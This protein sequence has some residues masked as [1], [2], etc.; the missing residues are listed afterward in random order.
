MSTHTLPTANAAGL[1]AERFAK[2]IDGKDTALFVLK[3]NHGMELCVCNY[4][5][6][7]VAIMVPDKA[8]NVKNVVLGHDSIDALINNP[9]PYLGTVV[10]RYAN[11]IALG[12]FTLDGVSYDLA[13]NNGPNSL[14]GGAKGFNFKVWDAEQLDAQTLVL[15]YTSAD[16][17]ENYPGKL[18]VKMTYTL[19]DDNEF[20]IDYEAS[21]DKP[22]LCNLTNHAFFNLAGIDTPSP[23]ITDHVLTI[24]ADRYTPMDDTSIPT[25]EIRNVEGTPFDFRTPHVIGERIDADCEQI[26]NGAGYDHNYV[27]NKP[28]AGLLTFAA[29]CV[30]PKTGRSLKVFTT[31]PGMQLYTGNWLNGFAGAHGATFPARSAVCFEAQRFPDSPNKSYFP[32]AVLRPG[33]RYT[34]TTVYQFGW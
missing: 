14:H 7:V 24:N 25:G 1:C 6:T 13:I 23:V 4:G 11:R 10:G 9:E 19:T 21:T 8:G 28:Q 15:R 31:E 18:D 17:E 26:R 29:E 12:K 16:G 33:E 27:L 3:N 2:T 34:Q 20:R 22:T 5:A 30:D 32:T